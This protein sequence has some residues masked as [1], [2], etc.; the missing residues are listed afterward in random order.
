LID[1]DIDIDINATAILYSNFLVC[2]ILR[3][4]F[5]FIFYLLFTA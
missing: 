3:Y 2:N 4:I 5:L 1:I